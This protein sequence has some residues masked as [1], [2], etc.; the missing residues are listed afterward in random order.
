MPVFL[1][2]VAMVP[3]TKT[4]GRGSKSKR[5]QWSDESM[6]AA[7]EAV[8]SGKM[9]ISAASKMHKVPRKNLDDRV[10]GHVKHGR[11]SGVGTVLTAE[12]E[13][14]LEQYLVYMAKCGFPLTRTMVKAFAWAI[15]KRVGKDD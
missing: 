14:S 7:M 8:S 4:S 3:K 2:R 1:D 11:R 10:K 6:K 5:L 13:N 9:N 12:E 15:A